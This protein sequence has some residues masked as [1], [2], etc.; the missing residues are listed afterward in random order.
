MI[1]EWSA[2]ALGDLERF[3]DFLHD[4]YPQYARMIGQ[5][6]VDASLLILDHP[7]IGRP[8]EGRPEFRQLTLHALNA[9]YVLQYRVD[10]DRLVILRIFHGREGRK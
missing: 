7:E 9:P 6:L 1:L 4:R 5:A 2:D 10:G 8:L 3:A